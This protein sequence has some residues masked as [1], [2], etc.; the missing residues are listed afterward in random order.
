MRK[1]LIIVPDGGM[2]FEAAGVADILAQANRLVADSSGAP[3]H[4]TT[5]ATAQA[6][7]VNLNPYSG[8]MS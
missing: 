7:C 3:L 8:S 6:L 4:Q 1:F 5:M 2:L